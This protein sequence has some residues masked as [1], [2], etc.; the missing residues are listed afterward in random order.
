MIDVW[1]SMVNRQYVYERGIEPFCAHGTLCGELPARDGVCCDVSG[2]E[3][4]GEKQWI[5][6]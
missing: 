4:L 2:F 6:V 3:Y 1:A 5:D